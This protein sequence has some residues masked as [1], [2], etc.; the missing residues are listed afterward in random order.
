MAILRL[1]LDAYRMPRSIGCDGTYSRIVHASRGITAGSGTATAELR[2]IILDL[3]EMLARDFPNV[4][5]EVHVDDV[6]LEER[7]DVDNHKFPL[8]PARTPP[9]RAAAMRQARALRFA[10]AALTTAA[11]IARATNATAEFFAKRGMEVS[12][13]KSVITGSSLP[14]ARLT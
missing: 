14:V 12:E 8:P 13:Q 7:I 3:L 1:A 6:N 5:P 9:K 2:N 10:K 4:L 11:D